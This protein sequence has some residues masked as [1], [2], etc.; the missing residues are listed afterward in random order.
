MS[1]D[2]AAMTGLCILADSNIPAVE[3]FAGSGASVRRFEGRALSPEQLQNG[4]VLLVRSVTQ[5][6][7]RL[8][9]DASVIFV[10]TATSGFEH[11]DRDYL[12]QHDIGF[13]H[14]PG[15]N[16]NS[17]IE[18]VIAAI[19]NVENYLERLLGGEKLGI[20][21]YGVIGQALEARMRALGIDCAIYDPWVSAS[22]VNLVAS[23]EEILE[24]TVISLHAELTEK[25]PWPSRHLLSD[26][27]LSA[28]SGDCL[29]INASRGAV[30]DNKALK[31]RL[32]SNTSPAVVLDVWEGEPAIDAELLE[33]V[34]IG[35]PHIAGYSTDGKLLGTR[36]L[37]QA[38]WEHMHRPWVDPGSAMAD[39][40]PL[41]LSSN[42]SAAEAIRNLIGQRYSI[43][44]DDVALR[45]A[46]S[47][48][49]DAAGF[50]QLRRTY[51]VRRELLGSELLAEQSLSE[52]AR[53]VVSSLGVTLLHNST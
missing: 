14:A 17:V 21:G 35:T 52:E 6:D 37:F 11:I 41:Q 32:G 39:P 33:A 20:V 40:P 50:D 1:V 38:L 13:A 19:A 42:V 4:N 51:P 30:V 5:V 43:R 16:A 18:Y 31:R 26:Y 2:S 29:L 3:H 25:Q 28:I 36:M 47:A 44:S 34:D 45:A 22:K 15:S 23:L 24:C 10:G 48:G 8:L 27:E 12:K 53:R 7:Q 9:E 46:L 49:S